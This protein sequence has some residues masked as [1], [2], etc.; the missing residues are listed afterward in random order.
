ME[1]LPPLEVIPQPAAREEK[2]TESFAGRKFKRQLHSRA[3]SCSRLRR[4]VVKI[5]NS[6]LTDDRLH[7]GLLTVYHCQRT[8][9]DVSILLLMYS[10]LKEGVLT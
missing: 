5:N 7:S 3:D 4:Q 6:Q 1:W 8:L 9:I 10:L 2:E